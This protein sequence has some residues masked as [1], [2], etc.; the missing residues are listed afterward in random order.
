MTK[1][2]LQFKKSIAMGIEPHWR[3]LSEDKQS[4]LKP[5][6]DFTHSVAE[7]FLEFKTLKDAKKFCNKKGL[8]V[9]GETQITYSLV[10][11]E[12]E[13]YINNRSDAT[14]HDVINEKQA[15]KLLEQD[16]A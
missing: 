6:L 2:F 4:A 14:Y 12:M 8:T 3:I 16:Y 1:V 15:K 9:V 13:V 10:G 7:E 11:K 5:D